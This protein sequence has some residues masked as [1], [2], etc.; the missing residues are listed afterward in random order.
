M[1]I[2]LESIF[3]HYSDFSLPGSPNFSVPSLGLSSIYPFTSI[4]TSLHVAITFMFS[5]NFHFF[6]IALLFHFAYFPL[7]SRISFLFLSISCINF[8]F[9]ILYTKLLFTYVHYAHNTFIPFSLFPFN[10]LYI[11]FFPYSSLQYFQLFLQ[12]F[13][14]LFLS[15][16]PKPTTSI[17][18]SYLFL[19]LIFLCLVE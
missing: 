15:A 7:Y 9:T 2:F 17:D 18:T 16:F 4:P 3:L 10:T 19:Y 14:S 5:F 11:R 13:F 6:Y 12:L 8:A 1:L